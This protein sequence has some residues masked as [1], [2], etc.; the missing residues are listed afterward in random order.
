MTIL[1]LVASP[2]FSLNVYAAADTGVKF[3]METAATDVYKLVFQAKTPSQ[4]KLLGIIFSFDNTIIKP[5]NRTTHADVTIV[6]G[7]DFPTAPFNIVAMTSNGEDPKFKLAK[8]RL[9]G[10][11][12]AFDYT[13]FVDSTTDYIVS[14]GSYVNM[15]EFYF[16]FQ[17]GKSASDI[18]SATFKFE[19]AND[20]NNMLSLFFSSQGNYYGII[21]DEVSGVSQ[22]RWGYYDKSGWDTALFGEIKDLG[23]AINPFII[24]TY[25]DANGDGVVNDLDWL[26]LAR[27]LNKWAGYEILGPR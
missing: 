11:R 6:D 14:S 15:F 20:V 5:I 13:L 3:S 7:A 8:W 22:Y 10:S 4:I 9:A 21:I 2:V 25:G 17:A 27:H 19:S 16:K 26:Y 1:I 18:T 12:T 24:P 23:E